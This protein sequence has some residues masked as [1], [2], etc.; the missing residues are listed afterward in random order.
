M[1]GRSSPDLLRRRAPRERGRESNDGRCS[2]GVRASAYVE[3]SAGFADCPDQS[4]DALQVG[5]GGQVSEIGLHQ[6]EPA[7]LV[8]G[9]GHRV[10]E[11]N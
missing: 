8:L 4:D 2:N 11:A 5:E 1:I 9:R 10:A 6:P 7:V 3:R